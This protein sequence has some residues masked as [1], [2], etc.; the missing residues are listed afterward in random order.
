MPVKGSTWDDEYHAKYYSSPKVKIHLETFLEVAKKPKSKTTK[1]K[2][3]ASHTGKTFT[4]EHKDNLAA[5]QRTRHAIRQKVADLQPSLTKAEQWAKVKEII[6][7]GQIQ[8]YI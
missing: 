2:M 5:A 4:Q 7:N 8:D 1:D 3:S 6:A